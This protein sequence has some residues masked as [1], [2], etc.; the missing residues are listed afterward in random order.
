MPDVGAVKF[1]PPGPPTRQVQVILSPG[2][3]EVRDQG[4]GFTDEDKLKAF[5]RFNRLSARPTGGETSTGLGLH[6]V[7]TIVE[8]MGGDLELVSTLG[9]GARFLIHL[10]LA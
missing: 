2:Q 1:M 7:K 10:P 4:P 8:A 5:G 9:Q 6:I 3:I